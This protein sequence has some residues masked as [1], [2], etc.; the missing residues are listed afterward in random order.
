MTTR[1]EPGIFRVA[2]PFFCPA[3]RKMP[4][5]AVE[6]PQARLL[7]W[8]VPSMKVWRFHTGRRFLTSSTIWPHT[9]KASA[10][11]GDVA[12]DLLD[13]PAGRGMA[14]VADTGDST[15]GVVIADHALEGDDGAGGRVLD[16]AGELGDADGRLG[17]LGAHYAGAPG[18]VGADAHEG[19]LVLVHLVVHRSD[20][21]A[22]AG[23]SSAASIPR[24]AGPAERAS[25]AHDDVGRPSERW[26]GG[27]SAAP[28]DGSSRKDRY[29]ADDSPGGLR[30]PSA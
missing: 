3:T 6:E 7:H 15:V 5:S 21:P 16:S 29:G 9:A 13:D 17:D 11:L 14:G 8:A 30:R 28:E 18:L 23:A 22:G 19:L 1:I 20:G 25:W 2:L 27:G 24:W 12:G 10:G 4:G 26:P